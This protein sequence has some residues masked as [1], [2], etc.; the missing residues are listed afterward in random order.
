[1]PAM[2]RARIHRQ[3]P[4]TTLPVWPASWRTNFSLAQRSYRLR[5]SFRAERPRIGAL[6]SGNTGGDAGS[7]TAI[8]HL[9]WAFDLPNGLKGG[10]AVTAPFGLGT[11]YDSEWSGRYLGIKTSALS[12]D[13][14]PNIAYRLTNTLSIGAGVSAQ[15][16]KLDF[17]SAIAQFA[18]IGPGTPDAFY[19][20][21]ADDWAF[22]FN[23]GALLELQSGTRIGLTYRSRVDHRIEGNLDFTEIVS[24]LGLVSGSASADVHLPS[25]TGLSVTHDVDPDLSISADVQFT[26]WSV[27]KQVTIESENPPFVNEQHFRDAWMI[28]VGA[29]YRFTD[30]WSFRAGAGWDQTPVTDAFRAVTLPD[31]SRY[32]VGVGFGYRLTDAISLDGAYQHSFAAAQPSMDNSANNSDPITHS[33]VLMGK[34]DVNVDIFGLSLKYKY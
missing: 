10:L 22:G 7:L 8:P 14:N 26:D 15:Y 20:F 21:K 1:M 28:S 4:S 31:Q 30:R 29:V 2:A 9:Y 5:W 32:L 11:E 3:R 19:R 16:L 24:V 23:F 6:L 17:S 27:F 12:I 34:Y 13:I 25:T 18:I 33:V